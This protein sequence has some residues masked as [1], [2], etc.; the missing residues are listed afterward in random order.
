MLPIRLHNARYGP[1]GE[2][3]IV[4]TREVTP[5]EFLAGAHL[6]S[7]IQQEETRGEDQDD[8][9]QAADKPGGLQQ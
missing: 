7:E 8:N 5:E 9:L 6:P 3:V 4:S 2:L 1:Y